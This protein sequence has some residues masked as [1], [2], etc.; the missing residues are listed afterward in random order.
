MQEKKM[1]NEMNSSNRKR[2][3]FP[4]PDFPT[5]NACIE[6]DNAFVQ[7]YLGKHKPT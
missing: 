1:S 4:T 7:A 5:T 6:R 2:W 3:D